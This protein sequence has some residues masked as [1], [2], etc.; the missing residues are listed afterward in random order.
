VAE[1]G[2]VAHAGHLAEQVAR[3]QFGDGIVVRQIDR[4]INRDERPVR[5]LRCGCPPR[6]ATACF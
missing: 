1:R 2:I 6:A 5:I 4:G 3:P